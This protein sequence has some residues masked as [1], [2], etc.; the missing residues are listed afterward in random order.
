MADRVK[1][2]DVARAAGVA[3]GTVS[4]VLNNHPAVTA[5]IRDKVQAAVRSL[6]YELDV[7]AQSM[8][9]GHSRLVACA[10]RD[11]DIPRF[12]GFIKE[13]ERI[14]REAGYTVLLSST[15]NSPEVELALLRAFERRRVD[16]VMMTISDEAHPGVLQVLSDSRMPIL[17]IDR[18]RIDIV[19]RVTADHRHGAEIAVRHLLDLGHRRIAMLV[20]DTRAFPSRAR[21]QGFRDA[22]LSAG[23]V[24]DPRLLRDMVFSSDDAFCQTQS[25]L[26]LP[27]PPT[28]IFAAAMDILGGVLRALR[29]LS[30]RVGADVSVVAGSDSELAE[31]HL[32]AVTAVEW[33][34]AEMGRRAATLLLDRMAGQTSSFYSCVKLPTR[35]VIRDSCRRVLG[36]DAAQQTTL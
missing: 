28:A 11:F 18:D 32:P 5:S 8:R 12:A 34:L 24:P 23:I 1:I 2:K 25:V 20:G 31:L 7:T 26:G 4:R 15:T 19:D 35:L 33:D 27:D 17:L 9:G 29:I 22:Y 21:V 10:I 36:E 30:L 3:V 14:L 16:G 6:G 13:A